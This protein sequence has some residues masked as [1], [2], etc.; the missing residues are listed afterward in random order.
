MDG[1]LSPEVRGDALEQMRSAELDVLVVGGGVVGAGA[2]LD[3]VTRGLSVGLIEMRDWSSG[4]SSRSSMLLNG[5][6][7]YLDP[8]SLG[9]LRTAERERSLLYDRI[10]P[11]LVRR[12]PFVF[13]LRH[14][15]W[16]RV[17]VGAALTISD[18]LSHTWSSAVGLASHRHLSRRS[19]RRIAP[20]LRPDLTGAVQYY[21]AQ[22]DDAR[23]VITLVRTAVSYGA[24]VANR[25]RADGLIS[26][27]G[28]VVG[29]R[30]TDLDRGAEFELRAKV[31][32]GA[33]GVWTDQLAALPTQPPA[34]EP[35]GPT[36]SE[37]DDTPVRTGSPLVTASLGV[38]LVVPRDRIR[39]STGVIDQSSTLPLLVMPW[40]RHWIIG[41]TRTP[42]DHDLRR[43]VASDADIDQLLLR[44]N[45]LLANPLTRDDVQGSYAGLW[46]ELAGSRGRFAAHSGDYRVTSPV[47]GL[48][49][50][51]AGTF[52]GYRLMA[53][54]TID[55]AAR[56]L[57]GLIAESITFQVPLLGA[58]GYAARWNQRHLLARRAGLHVAR[59]EHLLNRYGALADQLLD[60][61]TEVPELR[62][63]I[64]GAEDYLAV[65]IRYA[66]THEGARHLTDVLSR[67]TRISIETWDRGIAAAPYVAE[68]MAHALGWDDVETR[69][70]LRVYLR[71]VEAER[72]KHS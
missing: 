61:V 66:V 34:N 37:E 51:V 46:P 6:L 3:A 30:A 38:H 16:D 45:Q 21:G 12:V 48:V 19:V 43:P 8:L 59:V 5:G 7:R 10:A 2:A 25:V 35:D 63:P 44:V 23:Y 71:R 50:A 39:S 26:L 56:Q 36:F 52:S 1:R 58:D 11:H 29:V 20:G 18:V 60:L 54:D 47:R 27:R 17:S 31:V 42:W 24:L 68:L 53:R 69:S 64:P 55:V 22:V 28:R 67:R 49:L 14:S 62:T 57:G 41:T 9:R 4:S 13:P 65:E 15:A 32:V 70:Q 33:G 72:R 40:G